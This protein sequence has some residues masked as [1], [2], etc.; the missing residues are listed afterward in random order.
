MIKEISIEEANALLV[1]GITVYARNHLR[2]TQSKWVWLESSYN[3]TGLP[4]PPTNAVIYGVQDG[5][6]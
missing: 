5:G 4:I 6:D 2:T 3:G 1:L